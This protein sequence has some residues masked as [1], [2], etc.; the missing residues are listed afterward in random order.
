MRTCTVDNCPGEF[1]CDYVHSL[2]EETARLERLYRALGAQMQHLVIRMEE[3]GAKRCSALP[4][5]DT[6]QHSAEDM[7]EQLAELLK[8]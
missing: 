4:N 8:K 2:E 1:Q 6:K 7:L 3:L 5:G